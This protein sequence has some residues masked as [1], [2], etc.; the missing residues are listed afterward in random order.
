MGIQRIEPFR[1]SPGLY[2]SITTVNKLSIPVIL[3]QNAL[4]VKIIRI[5][6]CVS[7]ILDFS[8]LIGVQH[9]SAVF[10][11]R[12]QRQLR[13]PLIHVH[14]SYCDNGPGLNGNIIAAILISGQSIHAL[15][16][17]GAVHLTLISGPGLPHL[18]LSA[19]RQIHIPGANGIGLGLGAVVCDNHGKTGFIRGSQCQIV[20]P[21]VAS[22][23]RIAPG[24]L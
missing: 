5:E 24:S 20:V 10:R 2:E 7:G 3:H 17:V 9:K 19:L 4:I 8:C 6:P 14:G 12:G 13:L 23:Y 1:A 15:H 22:V 16:I 11:S 21:A 18:K